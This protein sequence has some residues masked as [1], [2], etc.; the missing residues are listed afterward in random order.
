MGII[1]MHLGFFK[2]IMEWS[3]IFFQDLIHF[4]NMSILAKPYP[5]AMNFTILVE[6]FMDIIAMHLVFSHMCGSREEDFL[7][8]GPF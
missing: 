7:K 1:T 3:R 6:G 5:G 2:C 8:I 4:Q